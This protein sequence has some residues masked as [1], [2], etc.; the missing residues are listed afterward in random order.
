ML[1]VKNAHHFKNRTQKV[2]WN[3]FHSTNQELYD[4]S[5]WNG[6][7]Q[8]QKLENGLIDGANKVWPSLNFFFSSPLCHEVGG[9]DKIKA[10]L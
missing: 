10:L 3:S 6:S 7:H 5:I 9:Y 1:T 8:H 2:F 4:L